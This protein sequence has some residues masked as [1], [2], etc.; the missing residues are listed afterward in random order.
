M[1]LITLLYTG[2]CEYL[3]SR[4][5]TVGVIQEDAKRIK[6]EGMNKIK[7][8]EEMIVENNI[9]TSKAIQAERQITSHQLM[10]MANNH[11]NFINSSE[12]E[13]WHCF[14]LDSQD[15]CHKHDLDNL[16]SAMV[17]KEMEHMAEFQHTQPSTALKCKSMTSRKIACLSNHLT[18][19]E[20]EMGA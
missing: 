4:L 2:V 7:A 20:N 10:T 5:D 8:A 6:E 3:Q 16:Q 19:K 12:G 11:H 15:K 13:R 1:I 17:M 18:L 9:C 14:S